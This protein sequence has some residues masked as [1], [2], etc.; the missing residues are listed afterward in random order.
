MLS[1]YMTIIKKRE[2]I[3]KLFPSS[4][5][6]YH[7]MFSISNAVRLHMYMT[8]VKKREVMMV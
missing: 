7:R 2:V 6:I 4:A 1:I 3:I 5:I 8:I